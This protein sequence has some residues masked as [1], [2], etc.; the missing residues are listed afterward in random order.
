[1]KPSTV[2]HTPQLT[3]VHKLWLDLAPGPRGVWEG[4]FLHTSSAS[5]D[6]YFLRAAIGMAGEALEGEGRLSLN[7]RDGRLVEV[8]LSGAVEGREITFAVW[9]RAET[10][11]KPFTCTATLDYRANLM[12][13]TWRH[14]CYKAGHTRCGCEGGGGIFELRR[15][16][17]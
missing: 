4:S 13:G 12:R 15:I 1:M 16:R 7:A 14:P 9:I 17:D 6:A 5:N 11:P 2:K 3:L 8:D 10:Q